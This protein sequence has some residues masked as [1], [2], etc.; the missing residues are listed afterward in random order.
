MIKC[1]SIMN[2]ER[3]YFILLDS[4]D[5][6]RDNVTSCE[7]AMNWKDIIVSFKIRFYVGKD[8]VTL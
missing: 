1:D 5:K 7:S 2:L 8:A 3:Y 4:V 6:V